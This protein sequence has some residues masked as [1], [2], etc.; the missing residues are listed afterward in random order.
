MIFTQLQK[1]Y[2]EVH[3]RRRRLLSFEI[4]PLPRTLLTPAY[5]L[6]IFNL[7]EA[8]LFLNRLLY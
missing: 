3:N 1:N 7:V 2:S 6:S 8:N 4:Y 5:H